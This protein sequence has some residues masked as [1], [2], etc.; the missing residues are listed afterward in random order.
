MEIHA[1]VQPA[2]PFGALAGMGHH[3][4]EHQG[5]KY[6]AVQSPPHHQTRNGH[7]HAGNKN[8][9]IRQILIVPEPFQLLHTLTST[10]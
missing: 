6:D 10:H 9:L 1:A 7:R 2:Q 4:G 3:K 5:N 8:H